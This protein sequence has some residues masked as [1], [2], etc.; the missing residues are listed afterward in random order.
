MKHVVKKR[1]AVFVFIL[2][3]TSLLTAA[4][5][6]KA[7]PPAS[8]SMSASQARSALPSVAYPDELPNAVADAAAFNPYEGAQND[9]FRQNIRYS[10]CPHPPA[11]SWL[12][13]G[14]AN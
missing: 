6:T 10:G 4:G 12:G 9:A 14:G 13:S 5:K 1:D 3:L 8:D 7:P 2:L 11:D